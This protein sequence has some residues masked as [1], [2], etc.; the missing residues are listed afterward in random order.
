MNPLIMRNLL[1]PLIVIGAVATIL[2]NPASAKSAKCLLIVDGKTYINGY[3]DFQ[4][5]GRNGSFSF[6]DKKLRLE[7][8]FFDLGPGQCSGAATRVVRKGTFG[9]LRI[10]RPGVGQ[11]YWNAGA[12]R[13]GS[14]VIQE[15]LYRNGACWEN[16]RVKLCAW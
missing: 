4:F 3:C 10:E 9:G 13:K 6:D 12:S 11:M 5:G 2:D 8:S 7:C 1:V 15:P 14:D 16:A